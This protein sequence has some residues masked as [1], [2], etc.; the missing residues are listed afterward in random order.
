MY[1]ILHE[2]EDILPLQTLELEIL[3]WTFLN[4]MVINPFDR[5]KVI[6][7]KWLLQTPCIDLKV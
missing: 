4:E 5:F 2:E 3:D 7:L 1:Q 6:H